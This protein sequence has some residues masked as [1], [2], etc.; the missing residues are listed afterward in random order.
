MATVQVAIV[1]RAFRMLG[2]GAAPNASESADI[3]VALNAMI[4]VWKLEKL[5]VYAFQEESL[6]L[7][8]GAASKTMGPTGDLAT[9]R[10]V[11]ILE[12]WIVDSQGVTHPVTSMGE[13]EYAGITLKSQQSDFPERFLYRGTNPNATVIFWPV[14][15]ASLTAKTV[16]RVQISSFALSDTLAVPPGYEEALASNLAIRIAPDFETKPSDEVIE[17]ARYSKRA[18]KGNNA[19]PI[20]ASSE[21]D[22]MFAN[23]TYNVRTDR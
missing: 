10:P 3:L 17:M 13:D 7:T 11:A 8:S 16:T 4:D 15:N 1:N 12:M 20:T 21:L 23:S 18:I 2:Q 19:Q 6:P 5:M 22:V 14:P 9:A